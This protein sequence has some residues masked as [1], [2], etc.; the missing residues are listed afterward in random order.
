MSPGL[1]L[2]QPTIF[3]RSLAG[4][5]TTVNPQKPHHHQTLNSTLP[6]PRYKPIQYHLPTALPPPG[7]TNPPIHLHPPKP[8]PHQTNTLPPKTQNLY[9]SRWSRK[10]VQ[11]AID[12]NQ[13]FS[14]YLANFPNRWMPMDIHLVMSR[15]GEVLDVFVP[16]KLNKEGK[17]FAF[18]RFKNNTDVQRL[19][20][21][22]SSISVDGLQLEASIAKSRSTSR[23]GS[24]PNPHTEHV[25]PLDVGTIGLR[26]FADAVKTTSE[27]KVSTDGVS[28]P[29]LQTTKVYIQ[30]DESL[31]WLQY[32]FLGVLKT[33]LP[34]S[35]IKKVFSIEDSERF[36]LIPIGG[37]SFIFKFNSVEDMVIFTNNKPKCIDQLFSSFR[38]W[39]DGDEAIDRFCWVLVKGSMVDWS[40]ETKER[41]RL[42]VAE[43]LVLTKSKNFINSVISA[44]VGGKH[45]EIG[46]VE[47]QKDPLDWEMSSTFVENGHALDGAYGP[48]QS[49]GV[50][51]NGSP[52]S[53]ST[54]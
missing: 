30:K 18:V 44:N 50:D 6:D 23:V 46:A 13:A 33:P 54:R 40:Q 21:S 12:N 2:G 47:S 24:I 16:K 4:P 45:C 52:I 39:K 41:N 10:A 49:P 29:S 11:V 43:I 8:Q 36:N 38:A 42:D 32:S 27:T 51:L 31:S 9:F 28:Q 14:L 37:T 7:T 17:R 22:I 1:P 35:H 26:S 48:L 53:S 25:I 15:Y 5:T 3:H 34:I 20:R 19:I